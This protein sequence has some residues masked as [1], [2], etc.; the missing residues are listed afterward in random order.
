MT[1]PSELILAAVGGGVAGAAISSAIWCT[2][3]RLH[4]RKI[5]RLQCELGAKHIHGLLLDHDLAVTRDERDKACA[6]RDRL[7]TGLEQLE[8]EHGDELAEWEAA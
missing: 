6:E 1:S 8:T 4:R 2:R 3:D 5:T 7:L